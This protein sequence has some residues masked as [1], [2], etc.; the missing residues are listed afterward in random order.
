MSKQFEFERFHVEGWNCDECGGVTPRAEFDGEWV[1]AQDAINREAALQAQIR[2]LE[3]QLAETRANAAR[4]DKLKAR[5]TLDE[6]CDSQSGTWFIGHI[7]AFSRWHGK[8]YD[9][10]TFEGA[11]D[12]MKD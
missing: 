8:P 6:P 12:A 4:F 7:D 9:Y 5:A 3:S 11:V 10:E 1:K 2:A